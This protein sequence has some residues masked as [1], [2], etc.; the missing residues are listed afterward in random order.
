MIR[1]VPSPWSRRDFVGLLA[2]SAASALLGACTDATATPVVDGPARLTARVRPPTGSIA[3]GLH[4]VGS[5]ASGAGYL[6]APPTYWAW[7][8]SP[9]VIG[10]HGGGAR[11][12]DHIAFMSPYAD[13]FGFLLLAPESQGPT[14]DGVDGGF[15]PDVPAIDAVLGEVFDRCV[16]DPARVSVAGFSDGASYALGLGLANGDLC[17]RVVAFSPGQIPPS[18]TPPHGHPAFFLSHGRKDVI[19][20]PDTASRLFVPELRRDG[21]AVT[22]T[23]FD[24]GHEVPAQIATSAAAWM[25]R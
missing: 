16:V 15:G 5:P 21:Y 4:Q 14:W 19:I 6:Y 22:Y 12:I 11:A 17:R 9:L 8:Q 20:P 24:G 23:E 13:R 18:D 10:F 7:R 2:G 3:P 1:S 25:V